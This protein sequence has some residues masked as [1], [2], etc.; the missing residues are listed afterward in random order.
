MLSALRSA[1]GRAYMSPWRRLA[2]PIP[3]SS[4]LTRARRSISDERSIP[5][6]ESALGANNSSIRPVPVPMSSRAPIGRSASRSAIARSNLRIGDVQRTHAFPSRRMGLEIAPGGF[7]AVVADRIQSRSIGREKLLGLNVEP[8]AQENIPSVRSGSAS[9]KIDPAPLLAAPTSPESVEDPN[10][11]GHARLA[12]AQQLR[13]FADRK[14]HD[15]QKRDDS[16]PRWIGQR[17][18][19]RGELE[20]PGHRLRI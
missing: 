20:V 8:G 12:L 2:P 18:E 19:K 17:L 6:A 13:Q 16:Q 10:V 15:P 7:C 1:S 5:I 11:P 14:L 3:A 9:W 4:S